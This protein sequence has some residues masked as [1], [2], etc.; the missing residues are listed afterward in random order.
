MRVAIVGG[1]LQGVEAVY[2]AHKAGWEV[3]LLDRRKE[4][5]A[6][7]LCNKF[8]LV[9]VTSEAELELALRDQD[10]VIPAME[11]VQAL[12]SLGRVTAK[13]NI[14][15]VFDPQAYSVSASKLTSNELFLRLGVPTP[16]PWP[17]CGFPVIAK[18]SGSSGSEGVRRLAT[19]EE[20]LQELAGLG[21]EQELV[22]EEYLPGPSFSIEVIGYRGQYQVLQIT[23]LEMDRVYDCKRVLAPVE[24]ESGPQEELEEIALTLAKALNLQGIMDVETI[25]HQGRMKVLEID[26]RLPS[27]TPTAVYLST[28]IN[29]LVLLGQSFCAGQLQEA[30]SPPTTAPRG[31]VYE[32]IKVSPGLVEVCGEHI[33]A[34]VGPLTLHTNFFGAEEAITNYKSGA[35]AWV[36]TLIITGATRED[37]WKKRC[38]VLDTVR[39]QLGLGL[40]RDD[41]PPF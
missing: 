37:A 40:Y 27:Q 14:P 33:M 41:K 17:D 5:P 25:L 31:V 8:C 2:L 22:I 9:D 4:V 32:H 12:E 10:L 15:F 18:P 35:D 30:G 36:A 23:E 39:N 26:A 34:G 3:T 20:Y 21:P 7:G 11:N 29:M 24:L 19:R 13:L 16:V 1:K 38:D 28:G 6:A